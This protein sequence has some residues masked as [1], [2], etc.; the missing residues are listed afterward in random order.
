M[1]SKWNTAADGSHAFVTNIVLGAAVMA[2]IW[3]ERCAASS[4]QN[5]AMALRYA[6]NRHSNMRQ[7]TFTLVISYE[8]LENKSLNGEQVDPPS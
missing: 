8:P 5:A 2:E 1:D 4:T 6:N 7:I 3:P